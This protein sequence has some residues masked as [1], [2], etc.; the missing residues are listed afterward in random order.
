MHPANFHEVVNSRMIRSD[1]RL[2]AT[3]DSNKM[4]GTLQILK[5]FKSFAVR[6]KSEIERDPPSL[7]VE[8]LLNAISG[9]REYRA[10]VEPSIFRRIRMDQIFTEGKSKDLFLPLVSSHCFSLFSYNAA[11]ISCRNYIIL[12]CEKIT[13]SIESSRFT[14]NRTWATFFGSCHV[15]FR[16]FDTV[17]L[18]V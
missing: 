17:R 18:I 5:M 11:Q 14:P 13:G 7:F 12:Y 8:H 4:Y 16:G 6:S 2:K 9:S 3:E 1:S 15:L 10:I